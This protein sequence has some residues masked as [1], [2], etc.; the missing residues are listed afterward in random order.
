MDADEARGASLD[1]S[2]RLKPALH[3]LP[4][5]MAETRLCA[6]RSPYNTPCVVDDVAVNDGQHGADVVD[7]G[8]G[9]GEVIA[10]E[11]NQVGEL[12]LFQ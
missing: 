1:G 8:F 9:D 10:I 6:P 12:A 2:R 11:D 5:T 3:C 4:R 7:L